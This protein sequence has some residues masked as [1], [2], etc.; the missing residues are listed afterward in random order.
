[1]ALSTGNSALWS[2]I[3]T[4]YN[5]LRTVQSQ[6]QLTQTTIPSLQGGS[7]QAATIVA[8]NN[9]INNLRT[10]DHLKSTPATG[11]TAPTVGALIKADILTTML[12]NINAKKDIC[13]FTFSDCGCFTDCDFTFFFCTSFDPSFSFSCDGCPMF[14]TFSFSG[15]SKC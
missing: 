1:M 15:G 2:D 13:H 12:N 4:I 14:W 6:H 8:L 5:S 7:I 11:I 10:E 9:A 3:T